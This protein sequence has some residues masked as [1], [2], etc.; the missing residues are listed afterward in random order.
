MSVIVWPVDLEGIGYLLYFFF[1]LSLV[2]CVCHF[3]LLM[4]CCK[5]FRNFLVFR[6]LSLLFTMVNGER[7]SEREQPL[8][9][10]TDPIRN[11]M[12]MF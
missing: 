9:A 6:C 7:S 3:I 5:K 8:T 10:A 1:R 2:F 12:F 4:G 11:D